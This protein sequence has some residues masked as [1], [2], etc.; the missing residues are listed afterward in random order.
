V[1]KKSCRRPRTFVLGDLHG[2]FTPLAELITRVNF[3]PFEDKLI[4]LG[5][6]ADGWDDFD[7]CVD[8]FLSIQNFVPIIGNHDFFIIEYLKTNKINKNWEKFGGK[9]TIEKIKKSSELAAKL[10][11][12]FSKAKYYH[13]EEDKIFMHGGFNPDRPIDMQNNKRFASNRK[14]FQTSKTLEEQKRKVNVTFKN[15]DHKIKEIF[16]GHSTTNTHKPVFRANLINL[17]TGIKNDGK[18]TLMDVKS[19]EYIQSRPAKFYY[20]KEK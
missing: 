7:L 4:F 17:D 10:E 13:V 12:Y 5:D 3:N 16:I 6:L 11:S 14:L 18:L 2:A 20:S 8:F 9:G 1:A 15:E 19:K